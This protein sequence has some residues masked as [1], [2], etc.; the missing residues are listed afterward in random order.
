MADVHRT[1]ALKALDEI[2]RSEPGARL[3]ATRAVRSATGCDLQTA[4]AA[5]DWAM[6]R[7][8][9][10]S[11]PLRSVIATDF[12]VFLKSGV[13]SEPS[14]PWVGTTDVMY[15]N[16]Y[17]DAEVDDLIRSGRATILRVG[18]GAS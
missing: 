16:L 3:L 13:T 18:G 15:V 2:G 6:A 4:L 17:D 7:P 10:A 5:V 8:P 1:H 12:A 14:M 9:A 11:L